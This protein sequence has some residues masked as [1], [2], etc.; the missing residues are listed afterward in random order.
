MRWLLSNMNKR[1]RDKAYA[2]LKS[3]FGAFCR[4]CQVLE[5][6]RQLVVD[7]RD[8]DNSNNTPNNW[9][10]LCR[11]CNYIKN[12]RLAE[13]PLDSVSVCKKE[14]PTEIRINRDKEP[15]FRKFVKEEVSIGNEVS[16][17][18]LINSGAEMAGISPITAKRYLKKMCSEQGELV[19]VKRDDGFFIRMRN[20]GVVA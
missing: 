6:E 2:Y 8:N 5:T 17:E 10:F 18:E 1:Q 7:H 20:S 15:E 19:R 14:T 4:G 12:P 3:R 16:E 13:R 9:Q 11:T